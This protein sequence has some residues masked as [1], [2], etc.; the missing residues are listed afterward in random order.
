MT[1]EIKEQ[2]KFSHLH[3]MVHVEV[4]KELTELAKSR[5][6]FKGSWDYSNTIRELLWCRKVF[7]NV[8]TRLDD[9]EEENK[10][11]RSKIADI[12]LSKGNAP[13]KEEK[14]KPNLLGGKS[15]ED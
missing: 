4:L 1:E 6:T 11:L 13:K 7:W 8:N 12:E 9:L 3:T 5:E 10:Y 2:E 15:T 14:K